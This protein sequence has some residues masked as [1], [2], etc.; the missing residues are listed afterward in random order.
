MSVRP[1]RAASGLFDGAEK[2]ICTP[3][4]N[5]WEGGGGAAVSSR[6]RRITPSSP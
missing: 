3:Y 2:T 1:P 5:P 6:P 4:Q